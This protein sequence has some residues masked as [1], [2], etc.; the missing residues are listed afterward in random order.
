M[1]IEYVKS[2]SITN[3]QAQPIQ[4]PS[5]GEGAPGVL[6][7]I[8]DSALTTAS[9][10]GSI[11]STY[12][13]CRLPTFAKIKRVLVVL[14]IVDSGGATAVFDINV[15]FSDSPYD[16]TNWLY[17]NTPG[18]TDE[19]DL[20]G[21]PT[22]ALTGAVTTPDA[23]ASPNKLFGTITAANNAQKA[24]SDQTFLGTVTGTTQNGNVNWFPL[25]REVPLYEFF[26][27]QN[28]Q[29]NAADPGGFFDILFYLSTAA[30]T[31]AAGYITTQ[32]DFV[33]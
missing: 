14:G 1:T 15:A 26:G 21:I 16:G 7:T 11:G 12:R 25:G 28:S 24:V 30:S 31:G 19:G 9:G 33:I 2:T 18:Q 17:S 6:R 22:T 3:L 29:G 4:V 10:M 23:Y 27:F 5:A 20:N 32:V 13:M 8:T